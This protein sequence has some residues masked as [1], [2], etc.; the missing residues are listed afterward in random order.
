MN[1]SGK[2]L[3]FRNTGPRSNPYRV[4]ILLVL[5]VISM[6]AVRA[7]Q[8]EKIISP[9]EPTPTAT[10]GASSFVLEGETHFAAGD[11]DKAIQSYLN[12]I[13]L[14]DQ[15]YQLWY[16]LARI[17]AYSSQLLTTDAEQLTRLQE[18]LEAVDQA[19]ELAPEDSSAHAIR[20]F[21]LDWLA[22]SSLVD[23][24][25]AS[26]YLTEAEQEAVQALQ[27]DNT[28]TLALAYYAEILVDQQKWLQAEQYATQAVESNPDMMDVHRIMGYVKETLGDYLGA[29]ESYEKAVEIMPNLTFLY[30]RI[31]LNY[32]VLA[33]RDTLNSPYY[34]IALEYFA[35]AATINEGLGIDDPIP[36]I[37]LGKTYSQLGEFY[38]ASLN[39]LHAVQIDP[40]SPDVYGQLGIVYFKARNYESAIDALKCAVRG[41]TAEESCAVRQCNAETDPAITIEGMPLTSSTEV[42]YY[43]Y[44]SVLS[45]MHRPY[46]DLCTEAVEVLELVRLGFP[47]DQIAMDIVSSGE[48]I[49]AS[50]GIFPK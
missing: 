14:D 50:Y 46:K 44:G 21:V 3:E 1:L 11:L 16:E 8:E 42:Y 37:A 17:R 5:V 30:I 24:E 32:R 9:F 26:N 15:N 25:T 19:I 18:A 48:E 12:A 28:N 45:A 36:Y 10:R 22:D 23:D 49:C 13:T 4:L 47:D 33:Q 7:R 6:F 38:A 2:Q 35:K 27:L 20:S 29:I 41:C 39:V 40:Y 34:P 43:S 31:G